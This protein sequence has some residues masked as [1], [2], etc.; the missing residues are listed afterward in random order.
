MPNLKLNAR[1]LF[2]TFFLLFLIA[3][4]SQAQTR[5]WILPVPG[6]PALGMTSTGNIYSYQTQDY[7]CWIKA[8][9]GTF[10]DFHLYDG[11]NWR[12]LKSDSAINGHILSMD[13]SGDSILV[14]ATSY[15]NNINGRILL[16]NGNTWEYVYKLDSLMENQSLYGQIVDARFYHNKLYAMFLNDKLNS[17]LIAYDFHT[18]SINTIATFQQNASN[19]V[20]LMTSKMTLYV[21]DDK[22]YLAGSYDSVDHVASQGF[23]YFNGTSFINKRLFTQDFPTNFTVVKRLDT[24]L[25]AVERLITSNFNHR[26]GS[27]L[28]LMLG[29]SI[30]KEITANLYT[31]YK[32]SYALAQVSQDNLKAFIMNGKVIFFDEYGKELLMQ[33][34]ATKNKWNP[35]QMTAWDGDAY[36]FK[37]NKYIFAFELKLP[38]TN[39][40]KCAY[41]VSPSFSVSGKAYLDMDDD[42]KKTNPDS[43]LK[44]KWVTLRNIEAQNSFLTQDDGSYAIPISIGNYYLESQNPSLTTSTCKSDSLTVDSAMDYS[45]DIIHSFAAPY[46]K[47]GDAVIKMSGGMMRRG[48]EYVLTI[49]LDNLGK[50]GLKVTPT[51]LFDS[52]LVF[53]SANKNIVTNSGNRIVFGQQDASFF[54]TN[55]IRIRFL[56]HQ[57]SVIVGQKLSFEAFIDST[58][59]ETDY[60]N[61][62]IRYTE[63]VFGP[64]DPNHMTAKPGKQV[65]NSPN[66]IHYTIEFQNKGGDT[67][68]NVRITDSIPSRLDISSIEILDHSGPKLDASISGELLE[69]YFEGIKLASSEVDE[70]KSK[71]YVTFSARLKD[72]M[73]INE[74]IQNRASIYFDYESP[75]VT[76]TAFTTR[77]KQ[78]TSVRDINK[79]TL[80]YT[81]FPNPGTKKLSISTN[82]SA[83][84]IRFYNLNGQEIQAELNSPNTYDIGSWPVGLYMIDVEIKGQHFKSLYSKID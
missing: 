52:K 76:N 7:L 48:Q 11:K 79:S 41:I 43:A 37:G 46:D 18:N 32:T 5:E 22:L 21:Q 26:T 64:Y 40:G 81:L 70:A 19:D 51:L 62:I 54:G 65:L 38:Y 50:P 36:F 42:C 29:D 57:D 49:H 55:K 8:Q 17:T 2:S 34:D 67:A 75:I 20:Y 30:I 12:I 47:K 66:S 39:N 10:P 24:N 69:F 4:T 80:P 59:T 14:V 16:F 13:N 45:R 71:G 73:K 58:Q 84:S 53:L 44:R 68:F 25:F 15:N 28:F 78:V 31:S 72:T 56:S 60:S 33:Y 27:R 1:K 77:V 6:D 9:H 74:S 83:Y 63:T 35:L 82:G 3:S 23:G 61:N